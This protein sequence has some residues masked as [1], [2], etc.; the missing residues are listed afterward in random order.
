MTKTRMMKMKMKTKM[1]MKKKM[2]MKTNSLATIIDLID[3]N[4]MEVQFPNDIDT[5]DQRGD[6]LLRHPY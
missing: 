1:K 2:K 3:D 4:R 6:C 5:R